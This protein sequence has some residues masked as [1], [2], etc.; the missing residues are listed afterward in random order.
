MKNKTTATAKPTAQPRKPPKR[1]PRF[2]I[3][4]LRQLDVAG[5]DPVFLAK[6]DIGLDAKPYLP[7][8]MKHGLLSEEH[9]NSVACISCDATAIVRRKGAKGKMTSALCPCCGITFQPS[10]EELRRWRADWNSLGLW[11]QNMAGT[12]G[13]REAISS[14]A[15]FLGHLTKRQERFEVYLARSLSDQEKAKQAYASIS[16]S[17]NG[18]GIVLSLARNPSKTTNP[19][20]TVVN[21]AECMVSTR[22]DFTFVWPD[23]VFAGKNQAKQSA[24]LTR[25]QNDPRQKQ[26]ESLKAFV[27]SKI[28]TFFADKY[29][30]QIA[31]EI[32]KQHTSQITYTDR[33]GEKQL[34]KRLILDAIAEVMRENGFEDWIS[35]RKFWP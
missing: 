14:T 16:Q 27:R 12:D 34:S 1:W 19:K 24:G 33:L 3:D 6:A 17:M 2:L 21:L 15:L 9:T 23:Y 7:G 8:L 18:S 5:D 22:A 11:V 13:E 29:H 26:K 30:H 32:T 20:M 25:A 10:D 31:D 35:G 4:M 28:T